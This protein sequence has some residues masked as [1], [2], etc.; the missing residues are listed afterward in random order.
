MAPDVVASKCCTKAS[1]ALFAMMAGTT[2]MEVLLAGNSEGDS[3]RRVVTQSTGKGLGLFG[4]TT[5][6]VLAQKR[7]WSVV[8]ATHGGHT[9]VF[10]EK[11][12]ESAALVVRPPVHH[13][14]QQ[15]GKNVS[16]RGTRAVVV[17]K[18]IGERSCL[19]FV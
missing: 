12:L 1:G 4:W 17:S 2:W 13:D 8:H 10:M 5:C 19:S 15:G 11:M 3:P 14:R 16:S 7:T 9:T 18:E 6:I